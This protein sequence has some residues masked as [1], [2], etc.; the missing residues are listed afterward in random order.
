MAGGCE[1]TDMDKEGRSLQRHRAPGEA[2]SDTAQIAA[3]ANGTQARSQ[4]TQARESFA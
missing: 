4:G 3:V 1:G 2:V